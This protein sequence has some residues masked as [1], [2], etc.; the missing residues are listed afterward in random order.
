MEQKEPTTIE[1]I[2]SQTT[3]TVTNPVTGNTFIIRKIS[4][5]DLWAQGI[6]VS[7]P[8]PKADEK[9][10]DT[11]SRYPDWPEQD[12]M[13]AMRL[14][15]AAIVGGLASMKVVADRPPADGEISLYEIDQED[16]TFISDEVLI[17]SGISRR[18]PA[19]AETKAVPTDDEVGSFRP[20]SDG[21]G[22][23]AVPN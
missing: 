13:R 10:L 2:R 18:A 20:E 3:K 17:F 19:T 11:D 1:T 23:D 6:L 8:K 15:K 14:Q 5:D 9:P 12:R 22:E 21:T 4:G 16:R 7:R